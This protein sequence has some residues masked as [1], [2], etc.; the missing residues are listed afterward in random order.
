MMRRLRLCFFTLLLISCSQ[1]TT[2]PKAPPPA[3][4]KAQEINRA[5][6]LN[7]RR[8]GTISVTVRGSPDDAERAVAAKATTAGATWYRIQLVS[9]TVMPGYWYST[10][11]LYGPPVPPPGEK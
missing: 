4:P 3:G 10:A 11:I 1:F 8:L 7:L 6:T 5:Q 9:E 2:T